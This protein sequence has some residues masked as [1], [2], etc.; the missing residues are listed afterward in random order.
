MKSVRTKIRNKL[1]LH[2]RPAMT[3]A[4]KASEFSSAIKVRRADSNDPVDGKSIMQILMLAG[5][6][7]TELEI[8]ADGAD[9]DEALAALEALVAAGFEEDE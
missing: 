8:T 2:A 7:G 5:T 9:A 6:M 4:E 1:G 3:F